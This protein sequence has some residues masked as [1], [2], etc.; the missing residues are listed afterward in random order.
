MTFWF[1]FNYKIHTF[2]ASELFIARLFGVE[3]IKT[4]LAGNYFSVFGDL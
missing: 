4:G 1:V 2:L 3:M